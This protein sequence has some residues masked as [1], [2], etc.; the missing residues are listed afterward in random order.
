MHLGLPAL[1]AFYRQHQ[2]DDA[3]VLATIIGTNGSTYRKPGAMMLVA[4]DGSFEG[5]I[6]GGCLENDLVEHARG[7]FES[8]KPRHLTYDMHAD[9]ALVWNLGIGCDG[10]IHL[11]LLRLDRAMSF[12]FLPLLEDCQDSRREALLAL[13]TNSVDQPT[14][15]SFA[16]LDSNDISIGDQHLVG[17][18]HQEAIQW[19]RWRTRL[20]QVSGADSPGEILLL[21]LPPPARV[22]IC[23]AGPDAV[24]LAR[25]LSDLDWDVVLVDHRPA[26]ARADRFPASCAVRE[27]RPD[28][29][30][31]S[32]DL[33]S[34]DA[35]VIMSHHLENDAE[36]LRQLAGRP[37]PYLGVLGPVARRKRL[38]EMA[39][40]GERRVFGPVGLDIGAELP[41]AIALS[42]AAEIHAVLNDRDGLSLTKQLDEAHE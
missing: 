17:I 15:G 8:G 9:E 18:L 19:P 5:L 32:I 29:L 27:A 22:L 35:A 38:R 12:G 14:T 34:L 10:V 21:R 6:S 36:Y 3:L 2:D 41:E 28:R 33:D 31:E 7:V 24:P 11:L 37:L 16:L 4:R 39:G 20:R 40:C 30:S 42:I 13:V 25:I 26:Y 1:M 23:G